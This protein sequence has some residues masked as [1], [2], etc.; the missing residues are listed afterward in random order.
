[1]QA[2]WI[3]ANKNIGVDIDTNVIEEEDTYMQSD[4]YETQPEKPDR[5]YPN[6]RKTNLLLM[7]QEKDL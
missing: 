6:G 1:M 7:I 2:A 3:G 5:A 4:L